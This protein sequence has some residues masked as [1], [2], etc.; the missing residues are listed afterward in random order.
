MSGPLSG[1]G[2]SAFFGVIRVCPGKR[3]TPVE[4]RYPGETYQKEIKKEKKNGRQE[5]SRSNY[6]YG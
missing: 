2:D 5:I 6:I 3:M 1:M 4:G